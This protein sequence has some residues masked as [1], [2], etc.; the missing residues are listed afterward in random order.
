[1]NTWQ[2]LLVLFGVAVVLSVLCRLAVRRLS[3]L[4]RGP[5]ESWRES[6][7]ASVAF[8]ESGDGRGFHG[9]HYGHRSSDG[10]GFD[11]GGCGG[12]DGGGGG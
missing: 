5:K 1:V 2:V 11:G 6:L 12:G 3:C 8:A 10:G 4:G 9:S 7:V